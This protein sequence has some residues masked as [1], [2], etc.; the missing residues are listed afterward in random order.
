M[1]RNSKSFKYVELSALNDNSV[2]E[3]VSKKR[4]KNKAKVDEFDWFNFETRVRDIY[5]D[6]FEGP[7][8]STL[9]K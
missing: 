5:K 7:V 8:I 9:E 2:D 6:E 4:T 3:Q 1:D